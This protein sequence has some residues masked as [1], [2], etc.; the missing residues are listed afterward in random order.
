MLKVSPI[1]NCKS[2]YTSIVEP[3]FRN[4]CSAWGCYGEILLDKLQN[5][6]ARIVTNRCYDAPSLPLIGSL[7]W[8]TIKE[9]IVFEAATAVYKSLHGL[10]P[11]YMQLTFTKLSE[12]GSRSLRNTETVLEHLYIYGTLFFC[13]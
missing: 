6:A 5:R 3:Q 2:M 12:N 11:E 9:M 1:R 4:C 8:L 13:V 7:E 10:A